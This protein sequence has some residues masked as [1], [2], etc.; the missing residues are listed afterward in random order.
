MGLTK[1]TKDPQAPEAELI[2]R[3]TSRSSNH[4]SE[5][6]V[7]T[8][9][10]IQVA[11]S[12]GSLERSGRPWMTRSAKMKLVTVRKHSVMRIHLVDLVAEG[13]LEVPQWPNARRASARTR[14][15]QDRG[16]CPFSR[17]RAI[18]TLRVTRACPR[19]TP[20]ETLTA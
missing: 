17:S 12:H 14:A 7:V 6:T 8:I 1:R 5:S 16:R 18:V 11:G 9:A 3:R 2:R 19:R 4:A 15:L 13:A 20:V 10:S